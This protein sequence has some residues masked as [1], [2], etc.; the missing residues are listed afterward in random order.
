MLNG[1]LMGSGPR[2]K[3]RTEVK[4]HGAVQFTR[5]KVSPRRAIPA[6]TPNLLVPHPRKFDLSHSFQR[7]PLSSYSLKTVA[8]A[9]HGR[10]AVTILVLL[11]DL[12]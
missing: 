1:Y 4:S 9:A 6:V 8:H 5:W 12:T 3:E 7:N 11:E 2:M 10:P